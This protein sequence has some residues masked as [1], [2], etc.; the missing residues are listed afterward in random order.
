MVL[1]GIYV[2]TGFDGVPG[3]FSDKDFVGPAGYR[4]ESS[5]LGTYGLEIDALRIIRGIRGF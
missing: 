1:S 5:F 4:S 2:R 3:T